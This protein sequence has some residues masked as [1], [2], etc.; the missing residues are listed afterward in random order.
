MEKTHVAFLSNQSSQ[1]QVVEVVTDVFLSRSQCL[2]D[3]WD[4]LYRIRRPR[5]DFSN[6]KVPWIGTKTCTN[7][8]QTVGRSKN[9]SQVSLPNIRFWKKIFSFLPIPHN[10]Y[11]QSSGISSKKAQRFCIPQDSLNRYFP[12]QIQEPP[13][14][15]RYFSSTVY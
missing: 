8:E 15:E 10:L 12:K 11:F 9:S 5:R 4:F 7:K 14:V 2:S 13:R 6:K 3:E 1:E